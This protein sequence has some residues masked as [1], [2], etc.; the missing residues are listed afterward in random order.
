MILD[1]SKI[2]GKKAYVKTSESSQEIQ[3][4][5]IGR[6]HVAIFHPVYKICIGVLVKRPDVAWM[7]RRRDAY[8]AL[9]LLEIDEDGEVIL[10]ADYK[11]KSV[12]FLKLENIKLDACVIWDG[13]DVFTENSKELGSIERINI[14]RKS[15]EIVDIHVAAGATSKALLGTRIIPAPE[16]VGFAEGKG[17]QLVANNS[18]DTGEIGCILVKNSALNIEPTGGAAEKAAKASVKAT[19]AAKKTASSVKAKASKAADKAKPQLQKATEDGAKA[20]GTQIGKRTSAL[21]SFKKNLMS[22]IDK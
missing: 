1:I 2:V 13:M 9:P 5:Q 22:E 7:F 3:V 10:E 21:K 8:C 6:I 14:D 11:E 20:L 19:N 15:G 17:A 4:K 12:K 18:I 16:I